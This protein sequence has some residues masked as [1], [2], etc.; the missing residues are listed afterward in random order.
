MFIHIQ[1]LKH[2]YILFKAYIS[3]STDIEKYWK[4]INVYII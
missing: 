3:K 2:T 1:Q 4:T